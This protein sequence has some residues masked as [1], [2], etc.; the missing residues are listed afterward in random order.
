MTRMAW[1]GTMIRAA[2]FV[3]ALLLAAASL[4]PSDRGG[5][6]GWDADL[7]P[8]LQNALHVPAYAVLFVLA[9]S[10]LRNRASAKFVMRMVIALACGLFGG[11]LEWAQAFVP[12]RTGSL[13]DALV[14]LGGVCLG[15]LLVVSYGRLARLRS[16]L[17]GTTL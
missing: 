3:Y 15:F 8:T 2:T 17:A 9:A 5:L 10:C 13:S 6:G 1:R 7:S 14:N 11:M 16:L 12:G 4:A